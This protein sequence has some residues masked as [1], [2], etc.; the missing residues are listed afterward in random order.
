MIIILQ[1]IVGSKCWYTLKEKWPVMKH[2]YQLNPFQRPNM[3]QSTASNFWSFHE[4]QIWNYA[5]KSKKKRVQNFT[6]HTNNTFFIILN[7]YIELAVR[8]NYVSQ[9]LHALKLFGQ[10]WNFDPN[11]GD[12]HPI[13]FIL[14]GVLKH[15]PAIF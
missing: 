8:I 9:L 14:D 6:S 13:F 4:G 5:W 15:I 12:G 10:Y 1:Q 11:L 7:W 3:L 2:K